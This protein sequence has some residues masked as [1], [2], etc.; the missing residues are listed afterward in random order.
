MSEQNRAIVRRLYEEVF[1]Q[2]NLGTV[3]ELLAPDARSHAG[4]A[5]GPEGLKRHASML[6]AAFPDL[7]QGIEDVIAEGDKVVVRTTCT[8]THV[9]ELMGIPPTGRQFTQGQIHILRLEGCRIVEHWAQVD[10]A[11]M[12]RQLG[13]MPTPEPAGA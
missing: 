11:G 8:G 12:M 5:P 9:G 13:I 6:R 1:N 4:P 2:G 10:N 7:H 3:D